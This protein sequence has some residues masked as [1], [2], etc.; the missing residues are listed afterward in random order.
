M[1]AAKQ[2]YQLQDIDLELESSEQG[3]RRVISQLG[4]SLAVAQARN[5]LTLGKQ[6]LEELMRQ[7]R[8]AE[9]EI[10]NL[11]DKIAI[12]EGKLYSGKIGN[13]KELT[14]LQHEVSELK[15]RRDHTED[16]VLEIMEQVER[17]TINVVA[18]SNEFKALEA[19][20]QRQQQQSSAEMERLKAVLSE[21]EGRRQLLLAEIETQAA[22]AYSELKKQK[23]R[24]VAKVE[25]G[26]CLGCRISLS[27]SE[28]QRVRS[29]SLVQCSSCGR[30][31]FLA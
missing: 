7:Q 27:T 5:Q 30:I 26:M 11:R 21:L 20:W 18:L 2:L 25:Q 29:G 12:L 14:N 6:R 4:E 9:W 8:S 1:N 28:L 31:L 3:L 16:K 23:G 19:E 22:E 24:A 17:A 15:V 10:E 13:P